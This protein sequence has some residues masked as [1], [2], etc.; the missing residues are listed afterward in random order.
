M[1]E[2]PADP[3][4]TFMDMKRQPS[5][6]L[7]CGVMASV[8]VLPAGCDS[9]DDDDDDGDAVSVDDDDG[10]DDAFDDDDGDDDGF[11]DDDGDDDGFDDDAVD[12]DDGDDDGFDDD[13][14]DDDDGDDD[15]FDDDAVDDDDEDPG[16]SGS[17]ETGSCLDDD[18]G[19][20]PDVDDCVPGIY[21]TENY[22][23]QFDASWL[24]L[25]TD[26]VHMFAFDNPQVAAALSME[27]TASTGVA[28]V[29]VFDS[30]AVEVGTFSLSP[31]GSDSLDTVTI[32][33]APGMWSVEILL[34][35]FSGNGS[36]SL[37]ATDPGDA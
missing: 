22:L 37:S 10:D 27:I 32:A 20:D 2:R 3:P 21:E 6:L 8:L 36:V 30:N 19:L 35:D 7:L 5:R 14:V 17:V 15:G 26:L 13:A 31:D 12:D 4:I 9:F 25:D 33:G 11:D 18:P 28:S 1:R 29:T 24:G 34:E 23:G 16:G